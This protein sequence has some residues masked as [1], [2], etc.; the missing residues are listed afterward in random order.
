MAER[1]KSL[2]WKRN[3]FKEGRCFRGDR[4]VLEYVSWEGLSAERK[5]SSSARRWEIWPG[6]CEK[7]LFGEILTRGEE[8]SMEEYR[9]H[10]KKKQNPPPKKKK[11]CGRSWHGHRCTGNWK[12][13][14]RRDRDLLNWSSYDRDQLDLTSTGDLTESRGEHPHVLPQG[15]IWI[16]REELRGKE[17]ENAMDAAGKKI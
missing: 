3:C 7:L 13:L 12:T 4:G 11:G 1:R 6:P 10:T 16:N 8:N 5:E 15:K 17:K 14:E 2:Y 9:P